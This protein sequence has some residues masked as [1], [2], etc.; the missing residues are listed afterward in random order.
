MKNGDN[1]IKG[2]ISTMK[3]L[4]SL[5][6]I[7][8]VIVVL[9]GCAFQKDGVTTIQVEPTDAGKTLTATLQVNKKTGKEWTYYTKV[10]DMFIEKSAKRYDA[11]FNANY[12]TTYTFEAE[13][14]GEEILYC[15]LMEP[16][17]YENAKVYEY[18]INVDSSSN[19]TVVSKSNYML[20]ENSNTMLIVKNE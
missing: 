9:T 3:K 5:F 16:G 6:L 7:V 18:Q 20:V 10:G 14:V 4:L 8:G 17:D 11:F 12:R 15:V 13:D 1:I 19:F 2:G